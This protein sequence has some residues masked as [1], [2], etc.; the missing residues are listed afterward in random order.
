ME[1]NLKNLTVKDFANWLGANALGFTE[2]D[3]RAI[4]EIGKP[5][6]YNV[7]FTATALQ[8][9]EK[10]K[11]EDGPSDTI[12][13]IA[14]CLNNHLK[15]QNQLLINHLDLNS[16]LLHSGVET[17]YKL[18]MVVQHDDSPKLEIVKR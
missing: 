4:L 8:S 18:S 17:K 9:P 14:Q 15:M 12:V 13:K 2:F 7:N 3:F 1:L 6:T 10:P 11:S 16:L 5:D